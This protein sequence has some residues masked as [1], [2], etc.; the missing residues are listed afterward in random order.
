VGV[1][2]LEGRARGHGEEELERRGS[3]ELGSMLLLP[4]E[5]CCFHGEE[6]L[7][8]ARGGNGKFPNASEGDPYL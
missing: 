6:G 2:Q 1:E 7:V 4:W 8:A 5:D 3:L